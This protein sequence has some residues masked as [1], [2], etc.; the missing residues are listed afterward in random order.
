MKQPLLLL[1]LMLFIA[2][3]SDSSS[4][5]DPST[6]NA[7]HAFPPLPTSAA[8]PVTLSGSMSFWMY[9]G[10]GGCFGTITDGLAEVW[11]WV[12]VDTCGETDYEENQ[13]AKVEVIFSQENQYG[14]EKMYTITRFL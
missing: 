13:P 7:A 4:D 9:E 6:A 5:S 14:P 8:D 3:C 1:A 11:L 2:G 12:D 10:D